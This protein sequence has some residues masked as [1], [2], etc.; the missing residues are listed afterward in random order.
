MYE[1]LVECLDHV[2][3]VCYKKKCLF[4]FVSSMLLMI[5]ELKKITTIWPSFYLLATTACLLNSRREK[6]FPLCFLVKLYWQLSCVSGKQKIIAQQ[7]A[8]N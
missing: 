2:L 8:P 7:S 4:S 1:T 3:F 5:F 6:F